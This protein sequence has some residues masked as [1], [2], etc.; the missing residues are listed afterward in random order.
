MHDSFESTWDHCELVHEDS[1]ADHHCS[2]GSSH[3]LAAPTPCL[4]EPE[5]APQQ[6]QRDWIRFAPEHKKTFLLVGED[7]IAA[8][9]VD[10]SFDGVGLVIAGVAPVAAHDDIEL[11]YYG[12]PLRGTVRSV[13]TQD[14]GQRTRLGVQW[15]SR[16]RTSRFR[17]TR[18]RTAS[19][20]FLFGDLPV[21]CRI[22]DQTDDHLIGLL[23]D[24]TEIELSLDD[25]C[26]VSRLQRL[27]DLE[28]ATDELRVLA[29]VYQLG[30]LESEEEVLHAVL[31]LEFAPSWD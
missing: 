25:L 24:G 4:M 17:K 28:G 2:S 30:G 11:V 22:V 7:P 26:S 29:A 14:G 19:D 6:D 27:A 18:C 3:W 9:V 13:V 1:A 31:N 16:R 5:E 10:E 15:K 12:L 8:E 20:F 23:P 21:A